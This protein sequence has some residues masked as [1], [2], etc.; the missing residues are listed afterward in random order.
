MKKVDI[1]VTET[2]NQGLTPGILYPLDEELANA[3]L[4]DG[5]GKK[6]DYVTLRD[7]NEKISK[8]NAENDAKIDEIK[9]DLRLSDVG[10]REL[11]DEINESFQSELAKQKDEYKFRLDA[12]KKTLE[13]KMTT[14][15]KGGELDANKVRQESGIHMAKIEQFTDPRQVVLYLSEADIHHEVA[16]EMLANWL[17]LKPLLLAKI[18]DSLPSEERMKR[19]GAVNSIY[20]KLESA[21]QNKAQK[22]SS[23]ELKI[24]TLLEQRGSYSNKTSDAKSYYQQLKKSGRIR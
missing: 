22:E 12:L 20:S 23:E 6:V 19:K 18:G 10:K 21:A 13:E 1:Y 14:L 11:I 16:R 24:L 8:L 17:T 4:R 7:V 9:N 5:K 2:N 3:V 15:D